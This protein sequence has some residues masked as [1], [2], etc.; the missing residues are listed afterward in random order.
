M[1]SIYGAL[2]WVCLISDLIGRAY[3]DAALHV[4]P[5]QAPYATVNDNDSHSQ[6]PFTPPLYAPHLFGWERVEGVALEPCKKGGAHSPIP[7]I[8]PKL[9]CCIQTTVAYKIRSGM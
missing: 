5:F 9:S 4:A 6:Q 7:E 2:C 1:A 8:S 3:C